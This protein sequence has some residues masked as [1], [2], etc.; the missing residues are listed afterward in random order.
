M[1]V[2]LIKQTLNFFLEKAILFIPRRILFSSERQEELAKHYG[3]VVLSLNHAMKEK[4]TIT[5]YI[6]ETYTKINSEKKEL[7]LQKTYI[8]EIEEQIERERAEYLKKKEKL[9][10]EVSGMIFLKIENCTELKPDTRNNVFALEDSKRSH[11]IFCRNR[12]EAPG[13]WSPWGRCLI[14]T[15]ISVHGKERE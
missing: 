1:V 7:E 3:K 8:Q 11:G 13:H 2:H 5:V 15:T 6:N 4:A 10:Q 12:A 14:C 9:N